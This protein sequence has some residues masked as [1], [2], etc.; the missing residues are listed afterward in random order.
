M[1]EK[2]YIGWEK[3]EKDQEAVRAKAGMIGNSESLRAAI[4]ARR[5][6]LCGTLQRRPWRRRRLRRLAIWPGL[7][8]GRST[9]S[10]RLTST[11]DGNGAPVTREMS[12]ICRARTVSIVSCNATDRTTAA[13]LGVS[14]N[15]PHRA[16][17]DRRSLFL[18]SGCRARQARV[19]PRLFWPAK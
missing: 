2:L 18:Q 19:F 4:S 6:R 15:R 8:V 16:P 5:P 1:S 13:N 7:L 11:V 9:R 10:L 12:P 3:G 14:R 17:L